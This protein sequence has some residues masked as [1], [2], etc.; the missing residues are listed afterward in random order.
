MI[1]LTHRIN[2]ELIYYHIWFNNTT[3]VIPVKKH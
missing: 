1:G 3:D 2:V